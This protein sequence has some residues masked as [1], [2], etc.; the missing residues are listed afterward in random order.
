[1]K[2]MSKATKNILILI[3]IG[4]LILGISIAMYGHFKTEPMDANTSKENI[5][6]DANSGLENFINDIFDENDIENETNTTEKGNVQANNTQTSS[7]P[8]N[9]GNTSNDNQIT[10]GEQKALE[11]AKDTWKKEWG[12]LDDVS[13]NN[14]SIQGDGKYIVSV[15]DSKT[16]RVIRR[17]VI[18]TI[19]GVVEEQ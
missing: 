3:I 12:N 13:F 10:P 9:S 4:L 8:E 19:T 7:K 14:E 17:Y 5:L 11:L 1:M 18:D 16:T 15:N 2:S 6:D